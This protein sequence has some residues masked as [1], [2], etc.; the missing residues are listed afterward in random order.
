MYIILARTSLE[1]WFKSK[2][3]GGESGRAP[4]SP[5]WPYNTI[6]GNRGAGNSLPSNRTR[7][8]GN[9]HS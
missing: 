9:S 1:I 5:Y 3:T 8:S 2:C 7:E 6:S 4:Q